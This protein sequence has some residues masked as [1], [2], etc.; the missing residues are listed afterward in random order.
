VPYWPWP[1][2]LSSAL[3]GRRGRPLKRYLEKTKTLS[4]GERKSLADFIMGE[5]EMEMDLGDR[6][7]F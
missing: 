2:F 6:D 5:Q 1:W 7:V 4:D 3:T